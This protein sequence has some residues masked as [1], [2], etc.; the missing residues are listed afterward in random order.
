[1]TKGNLTPIPWEN[2]LHCNGNTYGTWLRGDPRG[3]R[4]RHHREHVEGDY[5]NP[6]PA[7][8]YDALHAQSK[9]LMKWSPVILTPEQRRVAC[10]AL[11]EALLLFHQVEL[12][13]VCLTAKHWHILARFTPWGEPPVQKREPRRLIGLAKTGANKKLKDA[14]IPVENSA[15]GEKC[16]CKPIEDAQHFANVKLSIPKHIREGAAVDSLLRREVKG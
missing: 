3:W 8:M 12:V 4:S 13:D 10:L 16:R 11:A 9:T 7:E 15:W 2:W 1:M 6:P 5:K 14:G